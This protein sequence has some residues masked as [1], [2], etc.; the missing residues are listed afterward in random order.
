[1]FLQILLFIS[2]IEMIKGY[3]SSECQCCVK[4][5]QNYNCEDI[6]YCLKILWIWFGI[7]IIITI[8]YILLYFKK[9]KQTKIRIDHIFE[10]SS[11]SLKQM[12]I[13]SQEN[14]STLSSP[15]I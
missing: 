7:W 9:R 12:L 1:M 8:G 13:L 4:V 11:T 2:Y 6:S 15:N 3:C 10:L 5:D 14:N